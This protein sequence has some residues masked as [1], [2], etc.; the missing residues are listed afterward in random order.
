MGGAGG[1]GGGVRQTKAKAFNLLFKKLQKI[2]F[3]IFF[4]QKLGFRCSGILNQ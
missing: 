2:V 1:R 3:S 4:I